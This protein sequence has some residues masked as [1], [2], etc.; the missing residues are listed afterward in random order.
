[1]WLSPMLGAIFAVIL[2]LL[3][4]GG[5]LKGGIFPELGTP[6][7]VL[8]LPEFLK[9]LSFA[10][11]ADCPLLLVRSF[12]AGFAERFVPDN[13]DKMIARQKHDERSNGQ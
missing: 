11:P 6:A 1:M 10:K 7:S 13:L 8:N 5:A 3:F 12:V 9:N 4:A 2:A